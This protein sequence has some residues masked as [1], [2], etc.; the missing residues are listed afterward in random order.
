MPAVIRGGAQGRSGGKPGG[1][2]GRKPGPAAYSPTKLRGAAMAGVDPRAAVWIAA[3]IAGAAFLLAMAVGG[4]RTL[5]HGVGG[6]AGRLT[7]ALGFRLHTLTI[8]GGD[9]LSTPAIAQAAALNPGDPV[10]G[11]DL[12]KLRERV[13]GVGWVKSAKVQRLLPDTIVVSI[14]PRTLLAVWQHDNAASV[15]DAD[16][17]VVPEAQPVVFTQ[18]PLIVGEGANEAAAQILPLVQA[19]P[20]LMSRIDA[21]QRV[22]G[23]RWRLT[24]KDGGVIDLPAKDEDQ[25][26]LRFDQLDARLHC[27]ELGFERIDLRDP[28][29]TEVRMKGAP[30]AVGSQATAGAVT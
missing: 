8:M 23:R 24:L 15:V 9:A 3:G 5:E 6:A 16:G 10:L 11:I 12:D 26:L 14:V 13:E 30:P 25:A 21:L 7:G 22:D 19:R 28:S 1:G 18:L 27:L 29:A 17:A 4:A 2:R 20:R